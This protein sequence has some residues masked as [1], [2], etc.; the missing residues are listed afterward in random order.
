MFNYKKSLGQNFLK[1]ENV[2]KRIKDS[3]KVFDDD[4]IIEIGPGSGALTRYLKLF[5]CQLLC[6]EVDN[7]LK[8]ELDRL[9]DDKTKVTY[10]DFLNVDLVNVLKDYKYNNLYVVANLPYY[11]TTP[12]IEKIINSKIDINAMV[13]M[14]QNEVA[15]RL[16]AKV[17]TKSYGLMTV[18]LNYYYDVYKLFI[19]DRYSFEPIPNVDS[20]IIKL[21]KKAQKY[22]CNFELFYK[23]LK[24]SFRMK[25]KN[26]RNNLVNYDLNMISDILNKYGLT[27]NDRAEQ[28]PLECFIEITNSLS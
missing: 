24:D 9:E 15:D 5:H 1:D 27:I 21:E 16:S 14:V 6:F 10:G 25:R 12:I 13:L 4:L 28:I 7:R 18:Y 19:V 17:G 20:A 11:I 23:L 26:I 8:S 3:I 22:N 2:L